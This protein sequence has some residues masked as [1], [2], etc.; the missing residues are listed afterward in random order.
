M[1]DLRR[2]LD[3][4]DKIEEGSHYFS[5]IVGGFIDPCVATLTFGDDV[6]RMHVTGSGR[7]TVGSAQC[8]M[9]REQL[10]AV[11]RAHKLVAKAGLAD[12]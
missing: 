10:A 6:L 1:A 3:P 5:R 4:Q 11:A 9:S 8:P 12:R 7:F 2:L